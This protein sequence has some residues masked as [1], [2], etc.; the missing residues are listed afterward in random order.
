[1]QS[2][3]CGLLLPMF[4]GLCV[5]AYVRA[6]V[7]ACVCVCVCVSVCLF[8]CLLVTTVSLTKTTEPTEMPFRG[9][10]W[11]GLLGG[12]PDP[13]G[14]EAVL[15]GG[16]SPGP[17]IVNIRRAVDIF[18]LIRQVAAATRHLS[19]TAGRLCDS[20]AAR[21]RRRNRARHHS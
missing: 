3:K 21:A 1:M 7:R 11:G 8:V 9:M 4:R 5:C 16:S 20:S 17:L 14:E 18:N 19:T 12:G 13:P 6:C 15:F 10:D 2:I